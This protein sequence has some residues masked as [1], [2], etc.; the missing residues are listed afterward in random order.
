MNS[1]GDNML[2]KEFNRATTYVKVMADQL[3]TDQLLSLYARYKQ[4]TFGNCHTPKPAFYEFEAKKKWQAW[5][6]LEGMSRQDAMSS[7]VSLLKEVADNSLNL[8]E[9]GGNKGT[10]L[11]KSVSVMA[12]SKDDDNMSKSEPQFEWCKDGLTSELRVWLKNNS[13]MLDKPDESGLSLLHWA[14]DRERG[15]IAQILIEH[16]AN[17]N[18]K[19]KEGEVPLHYALLNENEEILKILLKSG[20]DLSIPN[21]DGDLPASNQLIQ[22]LE[23]S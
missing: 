16:G 15:D 3:N 10:Q 17:I 2:L 6:A 7:Y 5:K 19:D 22:K 18:I 8:P 14:C 4:A 23:K 21:L 13:G 1:T 11:P 9:T 20:A 12:K